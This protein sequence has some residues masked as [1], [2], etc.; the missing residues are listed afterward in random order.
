MGRL[1]I[2]KLTTNNKEFKCMWQDRIFYWETNRHIY[3][4]HYKNKCWK[5]YRRFQYK[6]I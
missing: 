2:T 3:K 5:K 1:Q 4:Y 6:L